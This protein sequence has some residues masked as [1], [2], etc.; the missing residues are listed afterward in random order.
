MRPLFPASTHR[1]KDAVPT[2]VP[3]RSYP[4]CT[5]ERRQSGTTPAPLE[6]LAPCQPC[7]S[8]A[9]FT[10]SHGLLSP[11]SPCRASSRLPS[12]DLCAAQVHEHRVLCVWLPGSEA[13]PVRGPPAVRASQQDQAQCEDRTSGEPCAGSR[14]LLLD[15]G[16]ARGSLRLDGFLLLHGL[17]FELQQL[18]DVHGLGHDGLSCEQ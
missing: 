13:R 4:F 3:A 16:R 17:L 6:P 15:G 7:D 14:Y 12:Q 1:G 2:W 9:G 5:L 10:V 11:P 8:A 18:L